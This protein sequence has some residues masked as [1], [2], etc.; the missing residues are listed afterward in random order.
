MGAGLGGLGSLTSKVLNIDCDLSLVWE[1]LKT[2]SS[3]RQGMCPLRLRGK[4]KKTQGLSAFFISVPSK[5]SSF[6]LPFISVIETKV[7]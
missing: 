2:S 1:A 3:K 7:F 5:K 4:K 6:T